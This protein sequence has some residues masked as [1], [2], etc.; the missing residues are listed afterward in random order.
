MVVVGCGIHGAGVAQAA[1]AQGHSVL[2]LEK[3]AVAAGTSSRSSKLIHG[4]LR[5]LETAQF[6]LVRECLTERNILL[7]IAPDLVKL[8]PF[9]LPIY[10][11]T[12]RSSLA[13]RTGLSI[14]ALLNG[15][16]STAFFHTVSKQQWSS[17][18]GLRTQDLCTVFKYFDAQTDD[19]ALTK[20]V[21]ESAVNLGAEIV[22]PAKFVHA[23][24]R[25]KNCI[26]HYECAHKQIEVE[27][28]VLVNAAGPWVNR[29]LSNI[30]PKVNKLNIT[31]VQGAHLVV[32]GTLRQ[33][34]FYLESPQDRRA[35][36]M[37]PWKG[38][39][40]IGTT[41]TEFTGEADRVAPL[42]LEQDYLIDTLKYYF[43]R[44]NQTNVVV[45]DCFAGLRVLPSGE[46]SH[47][48]RSRETQLLLDNEQ[49]PK[50]LTIYGGKLTAYRATA[51]Q[52]IRRLAAT[53]PPARRHIDTA[54]VFLT[55]AHNHGLTN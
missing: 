53:L 26:V 38:Q 3:T 31:L 11:Q 8:V 24:V 16:K 28:K 12:T 19:T 51:N 49:N 50:I 20:A 4:G 21:L 35:I 27:T 13:I 54:S 18:D 36:F 48:S 23:E 32:E 14:Y 7:K 47:F 30:T 39:I 9:Y 46:K 17:L 40:M 5:Y 42:Q 43:P 44:Y 33:G 52:V 6:S 34:I 15:F 22:M 55:V 1:A 41:E 29:V 2:V 25:E 45:L 37:M 10:R